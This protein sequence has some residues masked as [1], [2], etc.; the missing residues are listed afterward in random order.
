[1]IG[2]KGGPAM[3]C[4]ERESK[5]DMTTTTVQRPLSDMRENIRNAQLLLSYA[6]E[7]GINVEPE[8]IRNVVEAKNACE[9]DTP[10]ADPV[11]LE[12]KFWQA[13]EK[14]AKSVSPVTVASLRASY[15]IQDDF[16]Y[17]GLLRARILRSPRKISQAKLTVRHY[18]FWTLITLIILLIVQVYW[19][20]GSSVTTEVASTIDQQKKAQAEK[21][22]LKSDLDVLKN[23]LDSPKIDAQKR[24]ELT[25]KQHEMFQTI[26]KIEA[27]DTNYESTINVDH[28]IIGKW[29]K[30][31]R[32]PLRFLI[33]ISSSPEGD[34]KDYKDFL[35]DNIRANYALHAIQV[36]LLPILYGLLGSITYVLRTLGSQIKSLSYTSESDIGYSL[37]MV[38]GALAGLAIAW[39]VQPTGDATKLKAF[40]TL[41]PFAIAFL[42][43]YGVELLFLAMDRLIGTFT[44]GSNGK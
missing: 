11:G 30:C 2:I 25:A 40:A 42:A 29:N 7:A 8:V 43:G 38:L 31:W 21:A 34:D 9:S 3:I 15:D 19:V 17:L 41:S 33:R 35:S 39:F 22:K 28:E 13:T 14:L 18:R 23:S 12:T 44:S 16:S 4:S 5:S 10:P 26:S 32:L 37:R 27:E 24:N 6:S 36:Y 20:V 1:V